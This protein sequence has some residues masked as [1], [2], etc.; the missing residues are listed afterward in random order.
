[1]SS[2]RCEAL[3]WMLV[4]LS[5]GVTLIFTTAF[6]KDNEIMILKYLTLLVT[7][8]HVHYGVCIVRQ[9]SRYFNIYCFSL[10]KR[11]PSKTHS[12]NRK[13]RSS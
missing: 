8:A 9:M 3:N 12:D 5:A 1:M 13:L 2:T 10:K 6:G 7:V 11:H 4:P